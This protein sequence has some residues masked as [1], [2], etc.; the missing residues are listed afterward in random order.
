M[1][2]RIKRKKNQGGEAP[3]VGPV[4][5]LEVRQA[6]ATPTCSL[7][8]RPV[9][10]FLNTPQISGYEW[11]EKTLS[12]PGKNALQLILFF[13]LLFG[14]KTVLTTTSGMK[15]GTVAKQTA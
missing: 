13:L 6:G 1:C 3:T 10:I 9:F 2:S 14:I 11:T 15:N 7:S 4:T 12:V 5:L 8:Y